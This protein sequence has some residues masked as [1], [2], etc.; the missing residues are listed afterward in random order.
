M[1]KL[2]LITIFSILSTNAFADCK[3]APDM[4][5]NEEGEPAKRCENKEA[6]CYSF[7]PFVSCFKK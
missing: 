1:K 4:A 5:V 6:I 2:I 3:P 7:G